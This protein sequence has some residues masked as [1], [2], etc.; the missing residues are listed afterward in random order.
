MSVTFPYVQKEV[1]RSFVESCLVS[2]GFNLYCLHRRIII[3]KNLCFQRGNCLR[4]LCLC[5]CRI[6]TVH[7]RKRAFYMCGHMWTHVLLSC[8]QTH[9]AYVLITDSPSKLRKW[10]MKMEILSHLVWSTR[11]GS[12]IIWLFCRTFGRISKSRTGRIALLQTSQNIWETTRI[13]V[14]VIPFFNVHAHTPVRWASRH[15]WWQATY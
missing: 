15:A 5:L 10:I 1:N 12:L 4:E 3:H 8:R 11:L 6:Q 13:W 14:N 9:G 7:I 2:W